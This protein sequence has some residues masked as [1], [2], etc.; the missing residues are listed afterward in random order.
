MVTQVGYSCPDDREVGWRRVRSAP[1]T[2]RRGAR[3]SWLSLKTKVDCLWVVWSQ[4]HLDG[5]HR[6]GLKTGDDG[7]LFVWAL[8]P[9]TTVSSCLTSKPARRFSLVWPQNQWRRFSPVWH[10]TGSDCFFRFDLKI[11]GGFLG[12]ASKLRWYRLPSLSLKTDS[13]GLVIWASKLPRRFFWFE[14]QNQVDFSLSVAPQNRRREVGAGHAS[15]S[16]GLLR[17]E[18]S[19]AMFFQTGE[20]VTIIGARDTIAEV[21]SEAN[22]RRTDWCDELHRTLLPYL[23]CFQCIRF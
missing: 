1:C 21:A 14:P 16:S 6:F 20:G 18:A 12:W 7:F 19:L 11:G 5:F 23:Y 8:K 3:V 13:C 2:W 4:N 17:M 15:R 10:Q 9:M 22:W